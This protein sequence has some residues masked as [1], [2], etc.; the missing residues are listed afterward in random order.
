MS[1][2][3]LTG[4]NLVRGNIKSHSDYAAFDNAI[5]WEN[6]RDKLAKKTG[7][8]AIDITFFDCVSK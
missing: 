6:T 3:V 2:L 7:A 5:D 1:I 8:S 4:H